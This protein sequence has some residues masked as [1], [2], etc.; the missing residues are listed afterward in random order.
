MA[1]FLVGQTPG[2]QLE[3]V[4]D[5]HWVEKGQNLTLKKG[6]QTVWNFV[7]DAKEKK[8][9]F[10]PV[11][12]LNG[13][14][15]TN[16][17]SSDHPWH[18]GLWFS[19]KFINGQN[20]WEEDKRLQGVSELK[21]IKLTKNKDFSARIELRISY[22]MPGEKELVS[23]RRVLKVSRP[24]TKNN[25]YTIEWSAKFSATQDVTF[26]GTYAGLSVR[27]SKNK[28]MSY[29]SSDKHT[30]DGTHSRIHGKEAAWLEARID[31]GEEKAA[32]RFC[33][34]DKNTRFPAPW[35]FRH[36][37]PYMSPAILTK[38]TR[39]GSGKQRGAGPIKLAKGETLPL[40]YKIRVFEPQ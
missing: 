25:S 11:Y 30:S 17:K 3:A 24:D 33:Q 1:G 21:E 20:Y 35:F 7:Y 39:D 18:H 34:S 31:K 5:F 14:L 12:S 15:M 22:H 28:R 38:R 2:P 8:T 16:D 32:I 4:S 29:V 27:L 40:T 9:F 13:I 6:E 37:Y 26:S 10:H 23:E 36:K 19:W